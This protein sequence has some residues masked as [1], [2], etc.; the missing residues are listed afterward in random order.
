[1][2][3]V[4]ILTNKRQY[5]CSENFFLKITNKRKKMSTGLEDK[6]IHLTIQ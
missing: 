3:K 6:L 1:M 4:H 2:M 5:K